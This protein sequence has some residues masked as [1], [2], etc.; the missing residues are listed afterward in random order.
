MLPARPS[1]MLLVTWNVKVIV[2][3]TASLRSADAERQMVI[4]GQSDEIVV[5]SSLR[6]VLT[7]GQVLLYFRLW[8]DD[9]HGNGTSVEDIT[10][11]TS[12]ERA[13]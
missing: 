13:A 2:C 1:R 7:L 4:L 12:D 11:A 8:T 10:T 5:A 6:I 3:A 9:D